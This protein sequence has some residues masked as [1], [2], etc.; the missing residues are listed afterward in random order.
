MFLLSVRNKSFEKWFYISTADYLNLGLF[1]QSAGEFIRRKKVEYLGQL[2]N[3]PSLDA[4]KS[5]NALG[6]ELPFIIRVFS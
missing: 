1:W 6:T 2:W 3:Q 5:N 4:T